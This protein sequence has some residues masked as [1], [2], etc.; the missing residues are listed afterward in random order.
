MAD[1]ESN[2]DKNITRRQALESLAKL[3]AYSAPT[4][5]TLLSAQLSYAQTSAVLNDPVNQNNIFVRLC[6]RGIF[7]ENLGSGAGNDRG[8]SSNN[9]TSGDCR[10]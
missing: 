8:W 4:V 2:K 5:T 10:M 7:V 1:E 9:D 6:E 3:S